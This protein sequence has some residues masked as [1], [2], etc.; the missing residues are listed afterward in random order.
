MILPCVRVSLVLT[1]IYLAAFLSG[2]RPARWFGTRLLP[3]VCGMTAALFAAAIPW[4]WPSVA[5]AVVSVT[6]L[7]VGIL[8]FVENRDY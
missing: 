3:L 8:Y 6:A 4:Y 1:I 7:L 5:V 2:I